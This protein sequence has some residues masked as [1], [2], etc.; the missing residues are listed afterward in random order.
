MALITLHKRDPK[1][2][3]LKSEKILH[4]GSVISWIIENVESGQNFAVYEGGVC[5]EKEISRDEGLMMLAVEVDIVMLPAGDPLTIALIVSL[6]VSVGV[7]LLSQKELPLQNVNRNQ[8]SPN[9][10]LSDRRNIARPNQRIVDIVGKVKSIPDVLQREFARY[11][12]G[13]EERYGYYCFCRNQ[14]KVESVRDGDTL[15]SSTDGSSA[16]IY[17]PYKS[18]NNASPDIQIGDSINEDVWGVYQSNDAVGQTLVAPNEKIIDMNRSILAYPDGTI[19]ST[20]SS[21]DFEEDFFPLGSVVMVGFKAANLDPVGDDIDFAEDTFVTW[22]PVTSSIIEFVVNDDPSWAEIE[23]GGTPLI[24]DD[25]NR[26]PSITRIGNVVIGPFDISTIKIK[27]LLININAPNGMYRDSNNGYRESSSVTFRVLIDRLDDN[28]DKVGSTI[29]FD[30]TLSGSNGDD[31]GVTAE[32]EF[33]SETYVR[34]SVFRLTYKDFEYNGNV[35]DNI[36]LK[37]VFGLYDTNKTDFGNVTT[38]QTKRTSVA[39]ATAIKEPEVNAIVTEL[40]YKYEGGSFATSLTPNTQAMQSLI[41]L[42]LDPYV[43]RRTIDELDFDSLIQA[44]TDCEAYF[45][46]IEAGQCSYSFDSTNT[47]A[48]EIMFL[49]ANSMFTNLWREGRVL[50]AWFERPQTIP[51]MVFT[52]RSKQPNSETWLREFQQAKRKDSIEFKYTDDT[53]YTQETLYF[54]ADRSGRNPL[55]VE[56]P[57]IKGVSQATWRMMREYNKL[58][59]QEV[60]VEFTAT[61]EGRL[62]LPQQLI[63][64]VKGALVGSTDGYCV[65]VNGLELTLSQDVT[66]TTGD[67]HFII[68]KKRDGTTESVPVT[69]IGE[70]RKVQLDYAP[71]EDIYTGN[72]ALQTEFSFGNESRLSGQLMMTQE[73][74]PSSRQ[75]VG[76]KAINYSDDYYKDD[77]AVPVGGAFSSGFD[78]GFG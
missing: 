60:S 57:G 46:N 16:G 25:D 40:V 24:Y 32:Y 72:D 7:A 52:H 64:V 69:D 26:P 18:P 41:R 71:V 22:G 50:K 1:S 27:K 67:D 15:I 78:D 33:S 31:I 4:D 37:S 75:Y 35:V 44:Q 55:K 56:I 12:D 54:P 62:A 17:Y 74:N 77:P 13:I 30:T 53:L 45:D 61:E 5:A 10:S 68:L 9:N 6:V 48:Q 14:V 20:D 23:A 63:S 66:F 70:A 59:Y 38:I 3:K 58:L 8:E 36:K 47:S 28:L 34:F 73:I 19:E 11:T 43:G 51:A 42:A 76:I 49:I 65:A 21:I 39:Q 2:G 29:E